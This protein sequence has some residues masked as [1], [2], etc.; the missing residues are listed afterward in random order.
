MACLIKVKRTG[1][2]MGRMEDGGWNV[3]SVVLYWIASRL[4]VVVAVV[5]VWC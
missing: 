4:V 1:M 5:V 3:M 2:G